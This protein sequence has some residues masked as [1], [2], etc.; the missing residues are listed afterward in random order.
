[1]ANQHDERVIFWRPLLIAGGLQW[2]RAACDVVYF[3]DD[4]STL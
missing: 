2:A 4:G 3:G 1:M